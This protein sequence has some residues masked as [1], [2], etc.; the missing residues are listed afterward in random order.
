MYLLYHQSSFSTE[1][2]GK[3]LKISGNSNNI[4]NCAEAAQFGTC[5]GTNIL[6]S[7]VSDTY[8]HWKLKCS[9]DKVTNN[10]DQWEKISA[11]ISIAII[12]NDNKLINT[13]RNNAKYLPTDYTFNICEDELDSECIVDLYLNLVEG[14]VTYHCHPT[15]LY[16]AYP[17]TLYLDPTDK[18]V[19]CYRLAVGFLCV[20]TQCEM[21][22]CKYFIQIR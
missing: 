1:I 10:Q 9:I 16:P 22:K 13:A 7:K 2:K 11:K 14:S 6:S 5:F 3:L 15:T 20:N 12:P 18:E 8:H 19:P 21:A 4:C 17:N